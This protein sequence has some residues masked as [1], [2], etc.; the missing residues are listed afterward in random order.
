M[1]EDVSGKYEIYESESDSMI[2][3]EIDEKMPSIRFGEYYFEEN[4]AK[5]I[6][7]IIHDIMGDGKSLTQSLEE[8]YF[9]L[10]EL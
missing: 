7:S 9:Y 2:L 8:A 5:F 1:P 3:V 10:F 6:L 4:E